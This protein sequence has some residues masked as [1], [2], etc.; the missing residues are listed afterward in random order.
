MKSGNMWILSDKFNPP[1]PGSYNLEKSSLKEQLKSK[2][3]NTEWQLQVLKL[4]YKNKDKLSPMKRNE[5]ERNYDKI[6]E[7]LLFKIK[8]LKAALD[9]MQQEK[10]LHSRTFPAAY[11]PGFSSTSKRWNQ[12]LPKIQTSPTFYLPESHWDFGTHTR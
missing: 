12:E 7:K 2:L 11:K 10:M 3:G 4:N 1:G 6:C 8:E 9:H 5:L